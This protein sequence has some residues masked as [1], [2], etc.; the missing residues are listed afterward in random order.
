VPHKLRAK[1]DQRVGLG[2]LD[3]QIFRGF[4]GA[5]G[6]SD[7]GM[8]RGELGWNGSLLPGMSTAYIGSSKITQS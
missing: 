5:V 2:L 1:V 6:I 4:L 8:P 7:V 3:E